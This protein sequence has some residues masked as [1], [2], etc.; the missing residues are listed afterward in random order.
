MPHMSR[1]PNIF[2]CLPGNAQRRR[3]SLR[4]RM[5]RQAHA[6]QDER[7]SH[8]PRPQSRSANELDQ[9]VRQDLRD[10]RR[11]NSSSSD[12][13]QLMPQPLRIRK[14]EA[15]LQHPACKYP[16]NAYATYAEW[17]ARRQ[18]STRAATPQYS[19]SVH[20]DL[21]RRRSSQRTFRERKVSCSDQQPTRLTSPALQDYGVEDPRYE[22]SGGGGRWDSRPPQP[23]GKA[24]PGW[25]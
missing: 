18:A 15:T 22:R 5:L 24:P 4:E 17:D 21:A 25:I 16:P 19:S 7:R 20:H 2:D 11:T 3:D 12:H 14:A 23:V 1:V 6:N 10:L 8:K 13:Q 9:I